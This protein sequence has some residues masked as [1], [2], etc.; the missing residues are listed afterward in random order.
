MIILALLLAPSSADP[1]MKMG[2]PNAD[3]TPIILVTDSRGRVAT[4]ITCIRNEWI[5]PEDSAARLM[6]STVIAA[7][8]IA[9][10]GYL[11]DIEDLGP[12]KYVCVIL[13]PQSVGK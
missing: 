1:A 12:A 4:R 3:G 10:D 7:T 13:P 8:I 5:N 9:K 6:S 2:T 11:T